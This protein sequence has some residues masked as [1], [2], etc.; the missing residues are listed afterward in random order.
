MKKNRYCIPFVSFLTNTRRTCSRIDLA[1]CASVGVAAAAAAE[2]FDVVD[3]DDLAS[4]DV[5]HDATDDDDAAILIESN[6]IS[7]ITT[8]KQSIDR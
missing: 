5:E 6:R 1:A 7:F 8:N 2:D 4:G 3:G